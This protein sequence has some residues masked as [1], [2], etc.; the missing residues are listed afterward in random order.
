MNSNNKYYTRKEMLRQLALLAAGTALYRTSYAKLPPANHRLTVSGKPVPLQACRVSAVPFNQ[1]WPG[2]QRPLDQ[3]EL[4]TFATWDMETEATVSLTSAVPIHKVVVR[5]LAAGINPEIKGR[6]IR[7]TVPHPMDLVVEINGYHHA[8]HLFAQPP[9]TIPLAQR[10]AC[11]YYFGPGVHEIGKKELSSGD[12]VYLE[13]GAMVHGCFHAINAHGVSISGRGIIDVSKLERGKG[14]GAIR[15]EGCS[16][17]KVSGVILRD[18]D[19]WCLSLFGCS[20]IHIDGVKLIGLWR[21]NADGIDVCNSQRVV[22][23]NCFVRSFD[24]GLVVKGKKGAYQ[25]LSVDDVRFENC[26]VWCDWGKAFEIGAETVAP[27]IEK[28]RFHNCDIIRTSYAAM[29]ILHGDGAAIRDIRF[30]NIRIEMDEVHY[31]PKLQTQPQEVYADEGK[32]S[33]VPYLLEARITKTDYSQEERFGTLD[34]LTVADISISRQPGADMPASVFQ[35]ANDHAMIRDVQIHRWKF[36]GEPLNTLVAA[37]ITTNPFIE[38][39]Q[40]I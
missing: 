14:V 28:I 6:K 31:Q 38:S 8:I 25:H 35:G 5:P 1:V 3:T 10:K 26:V 9:V 16:D 4:A 7:F 11:T 12:S 34:G 30:E 36:N 15:L 27:A 29:D 2:Y 23:S 20:D 24:D 22:V 13:R 21:Y 37:R 33:Y 40:M 17:C 19:T 32:G 39:M 18:P